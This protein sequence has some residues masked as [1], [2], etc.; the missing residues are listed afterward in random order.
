MCQL[1]K[2]WFDLT[3][4][5]LGDA[6]QITPIN[7]NKAFTSLPSSNALIN[8]VNELGYPKLVRNLSI[9]ITNDMFQ[10]WRALTTIINLCLMRKTSGFK[11]PRAPRKHKF[12]PRPESP[13][14]LPN[15]EPVLGY[16]KFN[17]KGTKREV[18][19]IPIP[20]NLIT[21]DIQGE[22]YYQEYLA[23]VAKHQRYLA[24][25]TR[26]DPDSPTPKPTKTTKK[27]KPTTPKEDPRPPVLKPASSQ[28]TEPKSASTKTQ[29]K[30]RK[31]VLE[32]FNK[33]SPA[34]K[35]K[36]GLVT[37]RRNTTSSLRPVDESVAKGIYDKEHRV[38]D[39][40]AD[41]QRELKE[42]L[43]S[44]YDV[45]RGPLPPV[46]IKEPESRK[47]EGKEKVTKEQMRMYRGLMW[48]FKVKARLDQTLMLKI[49]ARSDPEH[50]DLDVADV[51]TQPHHEQMDEGFTTT[52]YPKVQENL[53]LMVEEQVILEEPT[54]SSRTL[55]S[56]QHLTKDLIFGELFFNDKPS[57][58]NNEKK[59]AETKAESMVSVTI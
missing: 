23:K 24:G 11:R 22:S 59:T 42:S 44:I 38:N 20:G 16:L 9:V 54:C 37:K 43:K 4:D 45:P 46:V 15:K 7:N 41:V 30:K 32:I 35:S 52:A 14:H 47:G 17:A 10:P 48:E 56:L 40:E 21:A 5:T 55:S 33:S 51:S 28:Q 50:M 2:Q 12:H 29:G 27:S 36:P 25:E 26:S 18:F 58:A 39:E 1:D 49:K 34:R 13:L 6:L 53:K 8:F 19:G 31:L 57:E 3:K